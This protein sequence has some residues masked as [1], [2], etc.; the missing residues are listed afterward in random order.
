MNNDIKN[1]DENRVLVAFK[2]AHDVT[3]YQMVLNKDADTIW[4][5]ELQIAV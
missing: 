3:E 5:T 1:T 4:A 2:P